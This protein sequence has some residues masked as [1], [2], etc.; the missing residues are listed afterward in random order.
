M[1][2]G[3]SIEYLDQHLEAITTLAQWHHAEWAHLSPAVSVEDRAR[4]FR[5][6]AVR[7]GVPSAFCA[8]VEAQVVGVACLV[9]ADLET[10]PQFTP[11]LASVLVAPEFRG[12]GVGSALSERVA[13]EAVLL[14]A[15]ELYLFTF[16]RQRLYSRL[17]WR[18]VEPIVYADIPG[19]IMVRGFAA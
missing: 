7:G 4:R 16:D 18:H 19:T 1:V 9:A 11:W 14:G 13:E 17:G 6:R 5:E 10:H 8:V 12:R 2:V 3:A 15:S